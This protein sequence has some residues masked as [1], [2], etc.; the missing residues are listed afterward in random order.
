M[1]TINQPT[2]NSRGLN[3]SGSRSR[4]IS[5]SAQIN[6]PQNEETTVT[7]LSTEN[8]RPEPHSAQNKIS[9]AEERAISE[10]NQNTPTII[11]PEQ[12]STEISST[13]LRIRTVNNQTQ[14]DEVP[15][16]QENIPNQERTWRHSF[17]IIAALNSDVRMNQIEPGKKYLE[18]TKILELPLYTPFIKY[19]DLTM[20]QEVVDNRTFKEFLWD[21]TIIK[22]LQN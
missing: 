22:L 11:N 17:D 7:N 14:R 21:E 3:T 1:S 6:K 20:N 9:N 4:S 16:Q 5:P 12:L 13:G 2:I 19:F 15:L 8:S 18:G 10:S